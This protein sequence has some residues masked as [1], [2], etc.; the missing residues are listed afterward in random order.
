VSR[1]RGGHKITELK[2]RLEKRLSMMSKKKDSA[3]PKSV[4]WQQAM[5]CEEK[6][7]LVAEYETATKRFSAAVTELQRKMGTSPKA[8]Y[9]QLTR[10]SDDAR[11]KS[12]RARLALEQ[13]IAT[14]RC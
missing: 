8:E 5:T 13:H 10:D 14:H 1:N 4:K 12:E 7:R 11:V 3:A 6:S 9:Q 2:D